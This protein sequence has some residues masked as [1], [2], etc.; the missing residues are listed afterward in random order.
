[1]NN[2]VINVRVRKIAYL[3]FF[4]ALSVLINTLRV[5]QVS[6][7]GFPIIAS[8]YMLGPVWGFFVG[9]IA[10]IVG[11]IVKPSPNAFNPVFSITSGLT[12]FIPVYLT[13]RMGDVYPN[14]KIWKIFI[15]IALGQI[16]TSVL[17]V[18]FFLMLRF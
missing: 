18:P 13:M 16:I 14:Y 9:F 12:G 1:M 15:S 2:H 3:S 8:G 10:D 11:F 5:G 4:V 6:F 17:L 7:G